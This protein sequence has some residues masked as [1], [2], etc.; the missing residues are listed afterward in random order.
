MVGPG[1]SE[2]AGRRPALAAAL[3]T[4]GVLGVL[5][6]GQAPASAGPG[7]GCDPVPGT[8][9]PKAKGAKGYTMLLRINKEKNIDD[10]ANPDPSTGGLRKRLR[11]RDIFVINTRDAKSTPEQWVALAERLR[12]QF[13]C[14]RI[15]ALNGLASDPTAPGYSLALTNHPGIWGLALDWESGDWAKGQS[16]DSSIPAWSDHFGTS[17]GRIG[18]RL[19]KLGR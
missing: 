3:L 16:Q 19:A 11:D 15:I 4:A 12:H 10:Y 7:G 5:V 17:R 8:L 1:S 18:K 13:P 14:N 2:I 9:S 6:L